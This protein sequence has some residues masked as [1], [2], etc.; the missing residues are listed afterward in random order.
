MK[1]VI[2]VGGFGTRLRPYTFSKPKPLVPFAN[3]AILEHQIAALVAAGVNHVILAVGHM[4]EQLQGATDIIAEKYKIKVQYSIEEFPLGTAGPLAL[5]RKDLVETDEPFFML[6]SDVSCEFP[7]ADM[8]AFHKNHGQKATIFV[9]PV[10]DPSKYGLVLSNEESGKIDQFLEKAIMK[11]YP[12]NKINAGI[13]ILSPAVLDLIPQ[14]TDKPV[15]VSIER[16]VFPRLV[17]HGEAYAMVLPGYW[18]DIGQPKDFV[19]GTALHL[20]FRRHTSPEDLASGENIRGN[21]LIDP[22]ATVSPQAIVG[23]NVTVGPGA[24]IEAGA[25]VENTAVFQGARI[26]QSAVVQNSIVGWDSVVG[27]WAHVNASYLGEDVTIKQQVI[28]LQATVCP[29]K[30][31]AENVLAA[32]IIL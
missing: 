32:K 31:V 12:T 11:T 28:V 4:P 7:L 5:C 23:P 27:K 19:S 17:A 6:N 20:T 16:E 18:M 8:L 10:E 3:L 21:V 22:T 24:V 15:P 14:I 26:Q 30:S 2:L 25:L 13:Y 9:T 1:A 29:H